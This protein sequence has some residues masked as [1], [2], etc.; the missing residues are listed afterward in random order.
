MMDSYLEKVEDSI[1]I[2]SIM[3][4]MR[5][6]FTIR[7]KSL[8]IMISSLVLISSLICQHYF[9]SADQPNSLALI[10]LYALISP[11]N[12]PTILFLIANPL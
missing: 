6:W 10:M 11:L 2:R 7:L 4:S 5:I 12:V 1:K 8:S 9:S 3:D